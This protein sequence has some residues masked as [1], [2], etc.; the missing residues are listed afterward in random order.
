MA[1]PKVI[2][3]MVTPLRG[4][5]VDKAAAS[6][7]ASRLSESGVDGVFV[8]GTTGEWYLLDPHERAEA[9]FAVASSA[10]AGLRLVAGV[11]GY[12]PEES[13]RLA[14]EAAGHGAHAVMAVPPIYFKPS[15]DFLREFYGE[16]KRRAGG[17]PTYIYIFPERMGY[18]LA[19]EQVES[20]VEAG[21]VDGIK[22]TVTDAAYIAGLAAVKERNPEFE[23]LA[24]GLEMLVHTSL[25]GGDG[26]VD[27]YSNVAPKLAVELAES[28]EKG[29]VERVAEL[30]GR[31]LKLSRIL[32][33][34][35]LPAVLKAVLHVLGAP[36]TGEV[37]KPLKP[38]T[39]PEANAT[40]NA[41]CTSY[42]DYLLP[43]LEC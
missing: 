23:V 36:I 4:G 30:Q 10:I 34:R 20:L 35:S 21:V 15:T 9:F 3:P 2:V 14:E 27:A 33:K 12:R 38:L 32:G 25:S 26:V 42:R 22:A 7:L 6:W 28:L 40:A 5:S 16:I 11:S 19:L 41:L 1:K 29:S 24:G 18:T 31:V 43:G 17:L 13:Y 37:R 8:P 39:Q